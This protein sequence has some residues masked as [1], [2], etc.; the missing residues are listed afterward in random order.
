MANTE[1]QLAIKIAGMVE[2]SLTD[3]CNLTKKQLR[4]VAK[5][6]LDASKASVSYT[7]AMSNAGDGIDSLWNGAT[8]V[9]KTT[10]AAVVA[11]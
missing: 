7:D 8:K 4:S 2:K 5:E 3:S 1:Y 10:A 6:A 11:A 9:V